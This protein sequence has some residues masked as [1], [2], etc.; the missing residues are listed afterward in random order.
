MISTK[1]L[2]AQIHQN[3]SDETE[4]Y[5]AYSNE[6]FDIKIIIVTG[7]PFSGTSKGITHE[8]SIP[9][10]LYAISLTFIVQYGIRISKN[11]YSKYMRLR[12]RSV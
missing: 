2:P 10:A 3:I 12:T 8:N 9:M 7:I 5:S 1:C 11:K 4:V 6:M